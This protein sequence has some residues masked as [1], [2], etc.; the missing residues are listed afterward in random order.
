MEKISNANVSFYASPKEI[1]DIKKACND[2]SQK[3]NSKKAV[4]IPVDTAELNGKFYISSIPDGKGKIKLKVKLKKDNNEGYAS[5]YIQY[6]NVEDNKKFISDEKNQ[7]QISDL[8]DRFKE[9]LKK[10]R[11][12]NP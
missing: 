7:M 5:K 10:M 3:M 11:E 4:H 12:E 2:L 9:T 1:G 6:G 8:L